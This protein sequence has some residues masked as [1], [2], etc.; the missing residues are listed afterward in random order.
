[1]PTGIPELYVAS[2]WLRR[3]TGKR[4]EMSDAETGVTPA[5]PAPTTQRKSSSDQKPTARLFSAVPALHAATL[6]TISSLRLLASAACPSTSP[7]H[8]LNSTK[9]M[10]ER[11]PSDESESAN[12]NFSALP[13]IENVCRSR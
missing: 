1:M 13:I 8:A 5:S 7:K 3:S 12:S 11:K 6:A 2:A 4:S 10:P 9:P